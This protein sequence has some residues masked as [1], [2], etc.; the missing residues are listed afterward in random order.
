MVSWAAIGARTSESQTHR[1]IVSGLS[2]PVGFKNTTS[3]DIKQAINAS[4]SAMN[5]HSFLGIDKH[6][7]ICI[8]KT[9]GNKY[10]HLVLRGYKKQ[11]EYFPNYKEKDINKT[12]EILEK[13][14]LSKRIIIDCSHGNS[15]KDYENQSKVF[16]EVMEQSKKNS[17]ILGVMLESNLIQGKQKIPKDLKNLKKGISITDA[18]LGWDETEKLILNQYKK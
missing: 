18:C 8:V 3:G 14:N 15:K 11:G 12:L 16:K 1:E 9:N 10:C 13:E 17:G 5:P 7:K 6:G 4:V 2:V